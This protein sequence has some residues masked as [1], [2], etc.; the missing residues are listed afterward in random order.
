[1]TPKHNTEALNVSQ[2]LSDAY[3]YGEAYIKG[4]GF[5]YKIRASMTYEDFCASL[6]RV[7]LETMEK[8]RNDFRNVITFEYS[9]YRI[10]KELQY[11]NA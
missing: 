5:Y 6:E 3:N 8:N 11:K 4:E 1:M 2:I 7:D 9:I 10:V